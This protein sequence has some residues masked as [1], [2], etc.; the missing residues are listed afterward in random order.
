MVMLVG[1]V[2]EGQF[3]LMLLRIFLPEAATEA[4]HTVYYGAHRRPPTQR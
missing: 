2:V 3:A 4:L 1:G